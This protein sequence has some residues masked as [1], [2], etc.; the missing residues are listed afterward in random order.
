[1]QVKDE[2]KTDDN[3][4]EEVET[5]VRVKRKGNVKGIVFNGAFPRYHSLS[6]SCNGVAAGRSQP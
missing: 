6:F 2:V 3:T 1:M 5:G 4:G